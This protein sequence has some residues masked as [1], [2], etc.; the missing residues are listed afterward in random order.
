MLNVKIDVRVSDIK[1]IQYYCSEPSIVPL[2]FELKKMRIKEWGYDG[3]YSN[4][5]TLWC[6]ILWRE[7]IQGFLS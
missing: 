4:L 1:L 2:I 3:I 5:L 7:I 6:D